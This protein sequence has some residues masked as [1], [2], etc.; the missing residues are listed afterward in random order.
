MSV[1]QLIHKPRW[2]E[3]LSPVLS[4]LGNTINEVSQ[5]LSGISLSSSKAG[6]AA[7]SVADCLLGLANTIGYLNTS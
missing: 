3:C 5:L 1:V 7:S 6:H 4:S 2:E